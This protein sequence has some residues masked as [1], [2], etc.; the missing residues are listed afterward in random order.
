MLKS[1]L[2][3]YIY[4]S[5]L[6][7]AFSLPL[8]ELTKQVAT[9]VLIVLGIYLVYTKNL[10]IQKDGIFF[11][12]LTLVI[13]SIIG[14]IFSPTPISSLLGCKDILRLFLF[15]IIVR[16]LSFDQIQ[17]KN[18]FL[19][20]ALGFSLALALSYFKFFAYGDIL[21]LKSV[22]HIN[23]SAIYMVLMFSLTFILYFF[24]TDTNSNK[25]LK[26]IYLFV[27]FIALIS[28][29]LT[30][31]RASM[32]VALFVLFLV[33]VYFTLLKKNYFLFYVFVAFF[34]LFVLSAFLFGFLGRF[35]IGFE[36]IARINI[37][38]ASLVAIMN[39]NIFFGIGVGNFKS[40]NINSLVGLDGAFYI[41][42][43]HNT[44]LTFLT[45]RGLFSL[46]G[47]LLFV[48]MLLKI[49]LNALLSNPRNNLI[50]IAFVFW[51]VNII[52]SLANTTFHHENA[53]LLCLFWA[54]ALNKKNYA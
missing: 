38:K 41:S 5:I 47:Y 21:E 24:N 40:L 23:H 50:L 1:K 32:Y 28:I 19:S 29:F 16:G 14:S 6:C 35:S 37:F 33:L 49:L 31:S 10:T 13:F 2:H 42:H 4:F 34:A 36:D 20:L 45:E 22:G 43:A 26:H 3:N 18:I 39:K 7:I 52:I 17:I 12:F 30:Q 27:A 48:G 44:F 8:I 54:L 25:N 15:F 51:I 9:F 53:Q 11:G 46:L